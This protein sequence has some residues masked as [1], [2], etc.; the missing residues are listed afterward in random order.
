MFFLLHLLEKQ[1]DLIQT[2]I[3]AEISIWTELK[4]KFLKTFSPPTQTTKKKVELLNFQQGKE[5][6]LYEAWERYKR[7]LQKCLQHE[8]MLPKGTNI[9]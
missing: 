9:L 6:T 4:A 8:L 1:R 2:T 5:E 7:M 3:S